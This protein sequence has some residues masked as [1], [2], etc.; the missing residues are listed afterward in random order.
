MG[1]RIFKY[2]LDLQQ[3]QGI[4]MPAGAE[5]LSVQPQMGQL[6]MWAAVDV[7]APPELRHFVLYAT[8]EELPADHGRFV[9]TVQGAGGALV[10]HLFE[11]Q[12]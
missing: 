5:V 12:Q 11:V 6:C 4:M 8:G 2:E 9:A 1:K 10:F 7:E 3:K